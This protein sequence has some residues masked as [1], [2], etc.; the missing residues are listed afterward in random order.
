MMND[1][2]HYI[3]PLSLMAGWLLDL[4]FGDPASLPHPVVYMGRWVAFWEKRLNNGSHR[5]LKGGVLAVASVMLVFGLAWCVLALLAA[6]AELCNDGSL[7]SVEGGI[8]YALLLAVS[9][10]MV[11]FCLAGKTLRCEVKMVFEA[12]ER[13]IDDGRRQVAR[14]VGRDTQELSRQEVATASLETLAENLSDGVV[15]PLFWL[16]L[17]GVPGMLAYKM[18]NT[19]DSMIGYKTS[20]YR[21]FGCVAAHVDD[22]ANYL[23]ARLTALLMAVAGWGY[24]RWCK[25]LRHRSLM[26][27]LGRTLK[28]SRCHASPNSGW[29][30]A[31]LSAFLDCRFGGSHDYFGE[32]VYK[33]YIGDNARPVTFD[34]MRCSIRLCF[35]VEVIAI[36]ISL[37]AVTIL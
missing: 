6:A 37:A 19:L 5:R 1:Y 7:V 31:A 23:P 32:L 16:A 34:D 21:L 18:V 24:S 9:T 25:L 15:A 27:Y 26:Y 4:K 12:L 33:P 10:A 14:I 2:I 8:L 11:F 35:I 3:L 28:Y 17:L 13:G 30:E 20:R 36:L 29:P 22:A